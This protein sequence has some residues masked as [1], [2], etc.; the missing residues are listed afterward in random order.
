MEQAGEQEEW[1]DMIGNGEVFR[2]NI[3]EGRQSGP[4]GI[5]LQ[6]DA[7]GRYHALIDIKSYVGER[8]IPEESHEDF[9]VNCMGDLWPSAFYAIALMDI[10]E[11]TS[12]KFNS[13]FV[14][15][16]LGHR[17]AGIRPD[18]AIRCDI[19]LKARSSYEDSIHS[20]EPLDR[21]SLI[22][23]KKSRAQ[24]WILQRSYGNALMVY[25]S[26]A[27]MW[28]PAELWNY[29]MHYSPAIL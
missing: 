27:D 19:T 7:W 22:S 11:Q 23:R 13:R 14:F 6:L 3:R 26:V 2:R 16:P 28:L 8:L 1:E 12:F 24:F 20:M 5:E 10:D 29:A 25:Q 9:V 15:G 18:E 21:V 4:G 17:T